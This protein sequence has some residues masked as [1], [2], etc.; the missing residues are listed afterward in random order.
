MLTLARV[1]AV[2]G[3]VAAWFWN[4]PQARVVCT[5]TFVL[6]ALTDWLDGYLARTMNLSTPFGAF[7]DP[8]ADKLMV[9]V[10]LVLLS[11]EPVSAGCFAGNTALIPCLSSAIICREIM[12]SGVRELAI[13][14]GT[15]ARQAVAVNAWGKWKTATQMVGMVLLL[16]SR[17]IQSAGMSLAEHAG[18][19]GCVLLCV[20]TFLA[21]YSLARYMQQIWAFV[22]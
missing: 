14:A 12:M 5:T 13:A 20:A 18:T 3:L 15:A 7:L 10:V 4:A 1:A 17:H 21:L 22:F 16:S 2:P 11:T 9:A 8:V 6:A 19:S